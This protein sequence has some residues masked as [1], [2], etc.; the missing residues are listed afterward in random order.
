MAIFVSYLEQY[1]FHFIAHVL[2]GDILFANIFS[3]SVVCLVTLK[4]FNFMQSHVSEFSLMFLLGILE[5]Q[6][7]Y[8]DPF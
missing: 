3:S 5:I 1:I 2:V 4:L 6:I 7:L 8:S